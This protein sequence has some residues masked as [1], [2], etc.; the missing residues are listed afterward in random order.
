MSLTHEEVRE[1]LDGYALRALV[2]PERRA[3]ERH[4]AE[5]AACRDEARELERVV[6]A[7]P[8]SLGERAPS[9][10][11]RERLLATARADLGIAPARRRFALPA[12]RPAWVLS[13]ALALISAASV[14]MAFQNEQRLE[15][16]Q[17]ER[18]RYEAIAQAIGQGRGAWYMAGT[19][20]FKGSGGWL[21]DAKQEGAA[22]V[23]FHDLRPLSGDGRYAIWMISSQ[24]KWVRATNFTPSGEPLQRVNL[25]VNVSQYAQCVVTVEVAESGAHAGPLA[26]QSRVFGP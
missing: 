11:L 10:A 2:D 15:A 3:A 1:L 8:E 21:V 26:M 23:L 14:A 5:C 9:A 17:A 19:E 16:M 18:D 7:I 24:G 6:D 22:F 20:A 13:G 4:L 12:L 25:P